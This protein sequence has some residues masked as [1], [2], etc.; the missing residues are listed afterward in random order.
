M[1]KLLSLIWF[2]L[3]TI[4][5]TAQ[6]DI[7]QVEY[8]I[9]KDEGVG[10]NT[11]LD[12]DAGVDIAASIVANIPSGI[13]V[14]YHKLYIRAKDENGNWSQTTRKNIQIVQSET[15]NAVVLGEYYI[16]DD[17]TYSSAVSFEISP[18]D[19]DIDQAFTAQI[20]ENASI[21]YHKIY[22]RVKDNY[23]NWS[24]TFRKNIQVVATQENP[25]IVA[26]E[27]F[28]DEDLTYGATNVMNLED[29]SN[30]GSWTFRV[31]YP[32][33]EYDFEDVLFVRVLD[34]HGNWSQTTVLDLIEELG[35]T[36][37]DRNQFSIYPNP[38][39]DIINIQL[40]KDLQINDISIFDMGGKR[41]FSSKLN[42]TAYDLNQLNSGIYI[43]NLTTNK[44]K[45]SYKLIKN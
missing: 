19:E 42:E 14:G 26:I 5:M 1:K 40:N 18:Q 39:R 45:A 4:N 9:D 29:P 28:F 43:L 44:G 24:Q 11:V 10:L 20:A 36:E 30:D 16:D 13:E 7:H 25:E 6:D 38:V 21:G 15:D 31:D 17:P 3:V 35:L 41:V 2:S 22:G 34:D 32:E 8:F 27:Y 37:L 12:I 33:G 23:G